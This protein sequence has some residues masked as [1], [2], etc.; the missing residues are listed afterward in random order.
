[1]YDSRRDLYEITHPHQ[2][3]DAVSS[4]LGSAQTSE[5]RAVRL[6]WFRG[7]RSEA[8]IRLSEKIDS[9]LAKD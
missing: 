9:G 6:P 2:G 7:R 5:A 1:M 8:T 4:V 3:C